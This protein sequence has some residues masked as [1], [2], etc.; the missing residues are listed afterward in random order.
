[1]S[2]QTTKEELVVGA[3]FQ[4]YKGKKY[5]ILAIGV[6]TEEYEKYVVYEGQY[7]CEKFGDKPVWVR[8]LKMFFETV[9]FS[10][11]EVPRFK[12]CD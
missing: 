12:R 2:D 5:K 9:E 1:M 10:G 6:H 7:N 8:P 3:L 4:H 11:K